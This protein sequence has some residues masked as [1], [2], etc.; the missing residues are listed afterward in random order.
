[1]NNNIVFKLYKDTLVISMI[2][3]DVD[4]KSLNNTNVIDMKELKF[5]TEYITNNLELVANFLNVVIIKKNIT[6]VQV[7]NMDIALSAIELVNEWEH[8]KKIIFKPDKKLTMDL[9]LSILDNKYLEE[10]ECYEMANYLIERLDLNKNIKV[11]T[12]H[13]IEFNSDFMKDNLLE[14][15]SDIYYKKMI[16]IRKEFDETELED[17]RV[18]IAIN[19]RLKL[20]K[21]M[22]YSNVL[23]NCIIDEIVKYKKENI[24]IEIEE[25]NNDLDVI[26]NSVSYIKKINRDY[27]EENNISF[28]LNYSK[29]YKLN[30]FFKEFNFKI[31]K[32]IAILIILGA[33]LFVAFDLFFQFQDQNKIDEQ[34]L[35]LNEIFNDA[36]E[37]NSVDDNDNDIEYIDVGNNKPTTTK[38]KSN[39]VSA[40]YTNFSQVFD[41]LLKK[42]KDTVGWLTLNDTKINYPVVQ[43]S[44]NSYYLNHDFYKR[45]NSMGWV[46]MDYRNDPVNLS[47]NTIIYSHNIK[48]GIMF[49]TLKYTLNSSWYKKPSNQILTYNTIE[50]N[51]RWQIFSI[52]KVKETDDYLKSDFATDED[53]MKFINLI[54]KRSIHDFKVKINPNS[55]IITLSTC[56]NHT[57]RTVVHA[58][59]LEDEIQDN[60][61]SDK[62]AEKKSSN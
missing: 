32:A 45:K 46:F 31:F 61:E 47:R 59:L 23:V 53:Y 20:I 60:K 28:K 50:K 18:F 58:V 7:N 33:L 55:K 3:K 56:S 15:Y 51:M 22:T 52:Y 41:K 25:K 29:E 9:F 14:S 49:G 48:A 27:F 38:K 12:R 30:N 37:V 13:E 24:V 11:T 44:N 40:Y 34:I 2:K 10:I 42:N 43:S 8:I 19:N 21:I 1:M 57:S 16:V 6:V 39:Y 4:Y 26:Y 62:I 17:F 36:E 54:Q 35:E 5:S